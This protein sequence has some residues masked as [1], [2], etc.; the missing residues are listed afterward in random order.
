MRLCRISSVWNRRAEGTRD[1]PSGA[2]EGK[3]VKRQR[4]RRSKSPKE[5]RDAGVRRPPQRSEDGRRR[6][7]GYA[8]RRSTRSVR[9]SQPLLCP[10][11]PDP[12]PATIRERKVGKVA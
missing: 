4:N 1:S 11:L 2:V 10:F 12:P 9:L 6:A 3:P 7:V 5:Q 8:D